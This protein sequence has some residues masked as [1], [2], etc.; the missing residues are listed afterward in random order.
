MT[1][2]KWKL[3]GEWGEIKYPVKTSFGFQVGA[4]I[5]AG[6]FFS[7]G[8]HFYG[9]GKAK[10]TEKYKDSLGNHYTDDTDNTRYSQSLIMLR[11]GFHF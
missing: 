7:F 2:S 6:D 11:L 3:N 5:M 9:L 8:V 1:T 10:F 4:G